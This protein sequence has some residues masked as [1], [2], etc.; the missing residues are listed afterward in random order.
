MKN[1]ILSF[2]FLVFLFATHTT[3]AATF[4]VGTEENGNVSIKPE[5]QIKSLYS[6]GNMINVDA[7]VEKG[8]HVAGNVITVNGDV[9]ES[10]YSGAGTFVLKGN[11]GSSVH[12]GGGNVVI[13]GN[14]TDDL[15]IGGG[16]VVISD[17]STIGG[18][19]IIGGG[20]VDIQG[21]V[22]G[23]AYLA[24]GI[25]T[26]GGQIDGSVEVKEADE[27]RIEDG[28]II[29][30]NLEYFVHKEVNISDG[31]VVSGQIT[32]NDK[33]KGQKDLNKGAVLGVVFAFLSIVLLIK[34]FGLVVIGL[35]MVYIFKGLTERVVKEGFNN[36]W[37]SFGIGF[38][39]LFLVPIF[40]V[41]LMITLV[42]IWL[43]IVTLMLY[44]VFLTI[45]ASIT[46][47]IFGVWLAH[48]LFKKKDYLS[49]WKI[50]IGGVLALTIV[51]LI[52]FVGWVIVTLLMLVSLG[53][54]CRIVIAMHK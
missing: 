52:P 47:I 27:L 41:V 17:K 29:G 35:I 3:Y 25:I 11:V 22:K 36:F 4:R 49:D 9:G 34:M 15:F 38:A 32:I 10:I 12:V 28:A 54:F 51:G 42:G 50:V 53:S 6:A 21:S 37:K 45:A 24:G 1:K 30:G 18:D 19:I 20:T 44:F 14:I 48:L 33:M 43:G 40:S 39:F 2:L 16:N 23:N 26:I 5:D 8:I 7:N 13:E 31:A 46:S